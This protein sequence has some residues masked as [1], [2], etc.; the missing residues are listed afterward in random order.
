MHPIRNVIAM[1]YGIDI[2]KP[3]G[4]PMRA[5]ADGVV[6]MSGWSGASGGNRV[7]IDHGYIPGFGNVQ[8]AYFHNSRNR[9]EVG[10]RVVAGQHIADVGSTGQS[11][12]PHL[13]LEIF[14]NG[15]HVNPIG[16]IGAPP[17]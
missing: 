12:G 2:P 11:T 13:H 14:V 10:Q 6:T 9:V 3:T 5:I 1:H 17:G 4:T 8:S 16:F 15:V 7:R